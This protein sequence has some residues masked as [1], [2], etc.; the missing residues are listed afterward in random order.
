MTETMEPILDRSGEHLGTT[1]VAI[2]A[3]RR[4]LLTLARDLQA[5]IEPAMA[6]DPEAVRGF[7]GV[8]VITSEPDFATVLRQ[9]NQE[10]VGASPRQ[11]A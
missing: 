4:H 10:L 2:I 5:G 9:C 1:D 8:D 6:R 11:L 7:R 3:L